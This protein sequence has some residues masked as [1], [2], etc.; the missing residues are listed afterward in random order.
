MSKRPFIGLLLLL[1]ACGPLIPVEGTSPKATIM[2]SADLSIAPSEVNPASNPS[3]TS[4]NIENLEQVARLGMGNIQDV[5][6]SPDQSILAIYVGET[7]DIYDAETF[8]LRQSIPAGEYIRNNSDIRWSEWN[9]LT[10]TSDSNSLVFS[11][12]RSVTFWDLDGTKRQKF[13][14][15]L[16]PGWDV[17]DVRVSPDGN[18][19]MLTTM[20]GSARCDGRDMNFALYDLDGE[21][22]FDRYVCADYSNNF[23]RFTDDGKV[24]FVFA[25]IMTAIYP[26]QTILVDGVSGS[27]LEQSQADYLDYEQPVPNLELLYDIS[28][29]GQILAYALYSRINEELTVHTKLIQA[30]TG[31]TLHEQDGLIEF[32]VD[33][34][35]ISWQTLQHTF[36]SPKD[37]GICSIQN[38]N[39][40]DDYILLLSS[41][42]RAIFSISHFGQIRTVELWDVSN[43][44]VK[45]AISYPTATQVLFSHD[46]RWLAGT[47]GFHAYVWD[48][49]LKTLNFMVSG[50]PFES[51]RDVIQFN[52]DSS[53]F[54]TGTFGREY[55]HPAQPYRNYSITVF[56]TITGE[57]LRE[58]K[59]DGEFL[60]DII[61]TPEKDLILAQDINDLHV[62]NIETGQELAA[63]PTGP[64]VFATQ[65]GYIWIV[66]QA[67]SDTQSLH[68]IAL[69]NYHTGEQ[70]L[71]LDHIL[72]Q[73]IRN[74]YLDSSGTK[75]L[76]Q[77]FLGQ[78]K[79]NGDAVM[80][81]DLTRNGEEILFYKLPWGHYEMSVYGDHFATNDSDGYVNLWNYESSSP[82]LI[83]QG[84]HRNWKVS[85][86]YK[87]PDDLREIYAMLANINWIDTLFLN[88]NILITQGDE[89]RFWDTES[90]YLLAEM[91]PDYSI[92]SLNINFDHSMMAIVGDDGIIRLWGIPNNSDG[93]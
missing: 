73:G 52:A 91:K 46:G 71:E 72:T 80:I 51:P 8:D 29:D 16:V 57:R 78:G 20:G 79:E 61:A 48:M 42:E 5:A 19:V 88:E 7:I 15:S 50:K 56:D 87:D 54:L 11:N 47:D 67:T 27:I 66:P 69:Y 53:R 35:K 23:V 26:T 21:L 77:L 1:S 62:W 40:V 60:K 25:S 89:L 4:E 24:M 34:G 74:I 31:K 92:E 76:A 84:N 36:S 17:V 93:P 81:F 10:F 33:Q 13:F 22:I 45:K 28:P 3:I 68:K 14:S 30:E 86:Q 39:S 75:L 63:L 38:I 12:G 59:P 9:L 49:Q 85:D 43:C 55:M 58:L 83:I 82:S 32:F 70:V 41:P 64:H 90:G 6:V 44:K 37:V 65:T 18:R 2:P